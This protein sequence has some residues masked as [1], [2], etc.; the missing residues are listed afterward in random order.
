MKRFLKRFIF[1]IPSPQ[2]ASPLLYVARPEN[3]QSAVITRQQQSAI[4]QIDIL[5]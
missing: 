4:I 5:K 1:P 2:A 3:Q